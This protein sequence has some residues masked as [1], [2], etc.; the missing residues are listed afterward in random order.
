LPT[1]FFIVKEETSYVMRF[2][3]PNNELESIEE[4]K[5]KE[6]E[7]GKIRKKKEDQY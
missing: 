2:Y 6:E 3:V 1:Y 7:K 4:G 5:D